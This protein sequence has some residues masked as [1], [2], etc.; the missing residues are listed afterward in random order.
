[1]DPVDNGSMEDIPRDLLPA[2]DEDA[3]RTPRAGPALC[4]R[5]A[6]EGRLQ[7]LVDLA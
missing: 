2:D 7:A 3:P 6:V 4:G 1:M 5:S